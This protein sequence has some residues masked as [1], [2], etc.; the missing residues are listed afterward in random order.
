MGVFHYARNCDNDE[1]LREFELAE[2]AG[3]TDSYLHVRI[4]AALTTAG[5]VGPAIASFTRALD[6]DPLSARPS[7][8]WPPRFSSTA[9]E[10]QRHPP[11]RLSIAGAPRQAYAYWGEGIGPGCRQRIAGAARATLE[12]MPKPLSPASSGRAW[13]WL[14]I[15]SA[16]TSRALAAVDR[17]AGGGQGRPE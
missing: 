13:V 4:A 16:I 9:R 8:T 11:F 10:P 2:R 17:A 5:P 15:L 1:A 7:A 12:R 6:L 3:T 14:Y